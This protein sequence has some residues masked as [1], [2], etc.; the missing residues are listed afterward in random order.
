MAEPKKGNFKLTTDGR[1]WFV[2]QFPKK[3]K[4]KIW[5][6]PILNDSVFDFDLAFRKEG[7]D[8]TVTYDENFEFV[9][10]ECE[11]LPK[12]LPVAVSPEPAP[13]PEPEPVPVF[14]ETN[15]RRVVSN[16][17]ALGHP[18]HN[19][20]T[21]IPFA[22]GKVERHEPTPH[23]ADDTDKERVSGVI[24]LDVTTL[25]PLATL[26]PLNKKAPNGEKV[27]VPG[28]YQA[29][30]IG[31]DVIV[32]ATGIRGMLRNLMMIL[33]GGTLSNADRYAYACQGRDVNLGPSNPARDPNATIPQE[34]FLAKVIKRGDEKQSGIICTGS[35]CLI[36]CETLEGILGG[37]NAVANL[38]KKAKSGVFLKKNNGRWEKTTEKDPNAWEL[39]LSGRPVNPRFKRE[40]LFQADPNGE[41]EVPSKLW[42]EYASRYA[43][44]DHPELLKGD[45]VWLQPTDNTL[46]R[47]TKSEQ[48]KSFQWARLG[49]EGD[50][51]MALLPPKADVLPDV[52]RNDGKVDWVTDLFGQVPDE[53]RSK[54]PSFAG[55]I[56]PSNLVFAD[57]RGQVQKVEMAPLSMPHIGCRG[58][59]RDQISDRLRGYKVYRND[60]DGETPW[61]YEVQGIY[62]EQGHLKPFDAQKMVKK[63][64]LLNAGVSGQ[65]QIA[66]QG[67]T[68]NDLALLYYAC[69]CKW[70]L[71]GGKSIGLGLCETQ[72]VTVKVLNDDGSV[73]TVPEAELQIQGGA[74]AA[75]VENQRRYWEA[76]QKPVK[77]V[78][79][80][81]AI[82]KNERGDGTLTR[83]GHAWFS[84]YAAVP[85]SAKRRREI[86]LESMKLSVKMAQELR[87]LPKDSIEAQWLP[88][89]N[90]NNPEADVQYGYDM[91]VETKTQREGNANIK[92]VIAY[93]EMDPNYQRPDVPK[94]HGNQG[95]NREFRLDNKNQRLGE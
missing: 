16:A 22:Q 86:G 77:N 65:L 42:A 60:V 92:R 18:F 47:I 20:Y 11:N 30:T 1:S 8:V 48:I 3:K 63:A 15:R 59:Y 40:A 69:C 79:Y 87:T 94:E 53:T 74:L 81:R 25:R 19:P 88:E 56:R 27:N 66:F 14:E 45:L 49:R 29:L 46:R 32:P 5:D 41:I 24:T 95:K 76:T 67:L 17:R 61:K 62:D 2:A 80:P 35:T 33:T 93:R 9:K 72:N 64:E 71:G 57:A 38:R 50:S 6:K 91:L 43:A 90:P 39:K 54:A 26:H 12:P 68:H 31:N 34:I 75:R 83:G 52:L 13:E 89:F 7:L 73:K 70:R 37:R 58:F 10:I 84:L 21:F 51:V 28:D 44:G 78:R 36:S 23:T 82:T 55:K 4:N 85:M